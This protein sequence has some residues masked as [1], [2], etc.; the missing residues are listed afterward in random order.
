MEVDHEIEQFWLTFK[1]S[2]HNFYNFSTVKFTR[3]IEKWCVHLNNLQKIQEY[4][5][6]EEAIIKYISL[7]AIDLMRVHDTD[8]MNIL[9]SNIKRWDVISRKYKIFSCTENEACNII[10]VLTDIYITLM[11]KG[12]LNHELFD[13]LE[14]FIFFNDFRTLIE[15]SIDH[16]TPSILEKLLKYNPF[17]FKQIQARYNLS[18]CIKPT[19]SGNKLFKLIKAANK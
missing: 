11:T 5:K 13:D 4:G 15:F 2:L 18:K 17:I 12:K 16:N 9:A 10:F 14:L 1:C 7:Y 8:N 6:I 19:I 3:P